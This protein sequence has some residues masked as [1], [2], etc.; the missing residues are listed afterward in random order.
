MNH[1]AGGC[2]AQALAAEDNDGTKL[3]DT[4]M[5]KPIEEYAVQKL[6]E[7][8]GKKL[9]YVAKEGNFCDGE[10]EDIFSPRKWRTCTWWYLSTRML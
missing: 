10:S 6:M 5:V 9:K 1:C 3:E 7:C 4:Y 8:D 2:A